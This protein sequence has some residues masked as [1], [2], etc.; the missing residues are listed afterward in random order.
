MN[1]SQSIKLASDFFNALYGKINNGFLSLWTSENKET[2][3]YE[4][5]E[6]ETAAFDSTMLAKEYNVYIGVGLRKERLGKYERGRNTDIL[7]LP[8]VWVEID[9]KGGKH[10]AKNLPNEQEAKV[11]LDTFPLEPSI[12]I[13]SGGGWH[14]YWLFDEAVRIL[15]ENDRESADRMLK[16][17]QSVFI[18]L[19][20]EKGLHIDNTSDLARV[21]RVPGTYNRKEQPKLV[22]TLKMSDHRY[23]LMELRNAIEELEIK[24][25]SNNNHGIKDRKPQL[26]DAKVKPII[27]GCNF[28]QSYLDNKESATYSEWMAALSIGAYCESYEKICHE[29]SVGHPSYTESETN[30]KIT[31]IRSKMKPRTCSTINEEFGVCNGCKYSNIINS[32]IAIGMKNNIADAHSSNT[33]VPLPYFIAG[34]K[35]FKTVTR[36]VKGVEVEEEV[37]VSRMAPKIIKEFSNIERN[38]VHYEITWMNRGQEK[39]EI[40]PASTLSTRKE[41]LTLADKGFSV[42][43][44]NYKD[45]INY[46]DKY[47]S[48]NG[49]EHC[50]MVERLGRIKN[51]F[52]HPLESCGVEIVPNDIGERQLLEGFE[53]KGTPETWKNEVLD[54][55][56]AYPKVLF[57]VLASFA[58][59]ILHDLEVSPFIIDLSGPTSQGKS[60]SLQV[61]RSVWGSESLINEW[62]ATRV[63]IERKAGFLNSFPL[64]MDDTRKADERILQS[65]IYMFSGGLSKGRG[66]LKGSQREAT[67]NNILIST[68]EVSLADYAAKAG[69]AAARIISIVD[70]PFVKVDHQFFSDIYKAMNE[71]HGAIGVEF[72]KYWR[73]KRN[74]F[75]REFYKFKELYMKKSKDNEVLTRLSL[76]YASV[77]FTGSVLNKGFNFDIDLNTLVCLF[78]EIAKENHALDKP[79]EIL[80]QMLYELD[81]TRNDIYYDN[82]PNDIKAVYHHNTICLM[83]SF[84]KKFLGPEEKMIRR[85]WAKRGYTQQFTRNEKV[86]DYKQIKH[87]NNKF[88]AVVLNPSCI[89]ELGFDFT[90]ENPCSTQST[91][92]IQ[93]S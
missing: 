82:L 59:V 84:L 2:K 18:R 57:I 54:R 34:N 45:L 78:D 44:I 80:E 5:K 41:L 91:Q 22:S 10:A 40:V 8:G 68:G 48:F 1:E 37:I 66:S 30:R 92:M 12:M 67:W 90:I 6:I 16:R 93:Q 35:L 86:V 4:V 73:E 61:A 60:T 14:C 76:Y 75:I 36:K 38:S 64:F 52:I 15:T 56:K 46:F 87:G 24:N 25:P 69:G 89:K 23:S 27:E 7:Y 79:K 31:E 65:V 49:L 85:E 71:N 62:N 9:I 47:L 33:M 50:H 28:I 42:N 58:S 11:I 55:I 20:K 43:D 74:I 19:A 81:S 13:N 72:I 32:P 83:P 53:I 26:P 70:Q 39:H 77:H 88:T 21:L 3:W 63:S 17:F 29:W 51:N